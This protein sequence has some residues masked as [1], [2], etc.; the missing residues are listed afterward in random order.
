VAAAIGGQG[1]VEM[2]GVRQ[3]PRSG[4]PQELLDAHGISSRAIEAALRKMV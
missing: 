1:R 2:L 3:I 4:K